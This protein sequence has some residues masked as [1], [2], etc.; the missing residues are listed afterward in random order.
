MDYLDKREREG[1]EERK[2]RERKFDY[3][4]LKKSCSLGGGGR[5]GG[6]T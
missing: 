3:Q 5:G 1:T 2:A 4:I 6:G